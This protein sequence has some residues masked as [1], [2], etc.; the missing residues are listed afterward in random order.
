MFASENARQ[1][2]QGTC[3]HGQIT[4]LLEVVDGDQSLSGECGR[5]SRVFIQRI[6]AAPHE[7]FRPWH[8][9]ETR[10]GGGGEPFGTLNSVDF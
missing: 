8:L 1:M 7:K 4:L 6:M 3:T 5:L 2:V 10:G 9:G